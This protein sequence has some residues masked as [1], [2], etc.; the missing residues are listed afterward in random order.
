MVLALIRKRRRRR[1]RNRIVPSIWGVILARNLPIYRRLP[2]EDQLELLGHVQVFLDE[3][4]FEGCGGLKLTDE[5][6]LTIAGQACLLLLHRETDYYPQLSTILVY[7]STYI[8]HG[9]RHL[10]GPIWEEGGQHLLGHTQHGLGTIVLAWDAAKQGAANASDG[11]NL[12]LHEFAHQLDFEDY[13]TNGAPVLPTKADSVKWARVMS[14]EFNALRSADANG[15]PTLLDTYGA[16]NPAEF[17]AVITEAFFERPVALRSMH[18]ELYK[19]LQR[20]Y[21]QDPVRYFS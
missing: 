5:I 7:P 15:I 18:P 20:F 11:R 19:E 16:T 2:A 14:R 10:E 8:A 21:R 1:L 3:K 12:I 6:R 17:F 13:A 9:E 4:K